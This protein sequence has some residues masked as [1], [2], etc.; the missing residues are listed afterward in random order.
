M[1]IIALPKPKLDLRGP[2]GQRSKVKTKK[3]G[4]EGLSPYQVIPLIIRDKRGG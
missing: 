1:E 4:K 2:E 3:A